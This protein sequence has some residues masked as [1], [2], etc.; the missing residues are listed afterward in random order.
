MVLCS[1]QGFPRS[2]RGKLG[3]KIHLI[4]DRNGRPLSLGTSGANTHDGLGLE[5][6]VRGIPPSA[7]VAARAAEAR[8]SCHAYVDAGSGDGTTAYG[9]ATA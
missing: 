5:P 7:A 9:H 1:R 6:L 2:P 8:R 3:S 4:T